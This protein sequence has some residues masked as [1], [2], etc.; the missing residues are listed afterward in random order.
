MSTR[1]GPLPHPSAFFLVSLPLFSPSPQLPFSPSEAGLNVVQAQLEF[2]IVESDPELW[3][4][5]PPPPQS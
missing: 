3:A 5:P 4:L 2:Y 1:G